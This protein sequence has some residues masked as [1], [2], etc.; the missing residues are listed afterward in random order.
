MKLTNTKLL[1]II[2]QTK[3]RKKNKKFMKVGNHSAE[4]LTSNI[5]LLGNSLL[6]SNNNYELIIKNDFFL[7]NF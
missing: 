7:L 6:N 1:F 4:F 2:K 3:S 5:I